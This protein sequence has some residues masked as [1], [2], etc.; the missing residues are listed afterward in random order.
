MNDNVAGLLRELT[1]EIKALRIA[2]DRMVEDNTT[3]EVR[4]KLVVDE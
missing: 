3:K 1:D 4:I 2:V